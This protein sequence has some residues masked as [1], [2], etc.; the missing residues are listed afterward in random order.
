[1]RRL[2]TTLAILLVV[3]VAGMTALVLL[4]NPNDF[5]GYMVKQVEQR[6]GYQLKL[7]GD[8]RWH[9]WPQLSILAGRMSLTAPGAAQPMVSAENMRLDVSLIPLFSHQL[10]VK[11]VMLK[12]AVIR[13]TPDSER[14]RPQNAPI[15]PADSTPAEPASGWQYDI[16]HL[17]IV[18]SLL[19]W[20]QPGGEEINFR[21][22]N[23]DMTQDRRQSAALD[24]ATSV[25]RDQRTLQLAL[26]GHMK[27]ADYPHRL[28]GNV[29][30]LQWQLSGAGMPADGIKGDASMLAS[31]QAEN[32]QFSL[33]QLV[34]SLNDS[35]LNGEISGKWGAQPDLKVALHATTLDLDK[36]FGINIDG[37]SQQAQ[38]AQLAAANRPPVIAVEKSWSGANSP[39][40]G[41]HMLLNLKLDA[42]RWR[43]L[44][45]HS[46]LLDAENRAG[47]IS[48]NTFSGQ[49][50][51]GRFSLPGAVDVRQPV[52]K[53]ALQPQLQTVAIKPL[54]RAFRLPQALDGTLT[55]NGELAGANLDMMAAKNSWQGSAQANV[56]NLQV[57]TLNIPQ[58][59]QR[60]I[61]RSS[62]RLSAD[63][64]SPDGTIQQL[65]GKMTLN[66]GVITLSQLNGEAQK[67]SLT[68]AGTVTMPTEALDMQLAV[69]INGGWKG[70]D[71]LIAAL[72]ESA[73]PLRIYGNW[74]NLQYSLPVDQLLRRQVEDAAKSRLNQWIDR[75]QSN[76]KAQQLK[77][78]LQR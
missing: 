13:A 38:A 44:D 23:L 25:S 16:G 66:Q 49:V 1:M 5:R 51:A 60:A 29:D 63:E 78:Q 77:K 27:I 55:L 31:W 17:R 67:L 47:E 11:Q 48:L 36:L 32:Q 68:G 45:L 65:S 2:I 42:V 43:G 52:A 41:M 40:T 37:V 10:S 3:I 72:A 59:V 9:V 54:L 61:S 58:M 34:A 70:D 75:N 74:Q 18:D 56:Q 12:N 46:V 19:I 22:L 14:Q 24:V 39:L 57:A 33:R 4:V 7:D 28:S 6:S 69:K 73:I 20:Q 64:A 71:R 76:E 35:Q 21:N 8:L 26:K 62:D 15:G 53:I 50:G 30:T